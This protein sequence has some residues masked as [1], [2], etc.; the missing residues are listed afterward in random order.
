MPTWLASDA[1]QA[2]TSANSCSCSARVPLRTAWASSPTSSASHATVAGTPRWRSWWPY[3]DSISCWNARR[4]IGGPSVGGGRDRTSGRHVPHDEPMAA[5]VAQGTGPPL[6]LGSG[7]LA[8]EAV[9]VRT[10]EPVRVV[11]D[12]TEV[13]Q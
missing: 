9:V 1:S 8:A 4:S 13:H 5:E 10:V 2:S 12:G 7:G 6:D 3:V 11:A